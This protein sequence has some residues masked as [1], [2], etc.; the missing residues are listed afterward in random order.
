MDQIARGTS[1][2]LASTAARAT[3][4]W[5]RFMA[6]WVPVTLLYAAWRIWSGAAEAIPLGSL[7]WI[8]PLVAVVTYIGALAFAALAPLRARRYGYYLTWALAGVIALLALLVLGWV[9]AAVL[10]EDT[11]IFINPWLW[12]AAVGGGTF[13][14]LGYGWEARRSGL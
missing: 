7:V 4:G 8:V 5:L 12:A 6:V 11:A 10:G 1:T 14:G 2:W 3:Q 13:T 9:A